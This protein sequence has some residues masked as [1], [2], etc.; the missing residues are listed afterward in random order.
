MPGVDLS[1]AGC[2]AVEPSR[3]L[4]LQSPSTLL[5]VLGAPLLHA[6]LRA[7]TRPGWAGQGLHKSGHGQG[8]RV[9]E[10]GGRAGRSAKT[11]EQLSKG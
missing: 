7:H 6:P 5:H 11:L 4:S 3:K 8:N 10:R 9:G 1:R 2:T